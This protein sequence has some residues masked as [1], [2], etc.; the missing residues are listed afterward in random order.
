MNNNVEI[1]PFSEEYAEGV[2]N[3]AI[4]AWTPIRE[5]YR[6]LLGD[7]LYSMTFDN[8]QTSKA[9]GVLKAMRSGRG[10]L[11]VCDGELAGFVYYIFKEGNMS[12]EIG[13]NAVSFKYRGRG[14]AQLMYSHVIEKMKAE[15]ARFVTVVTGLDEG[16]A[17]ARR[18]Y[19]KAGFEKNLPSVCYY[20]RL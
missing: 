13:G 14:I 15:G 5:S 19:E 18:A 2:A 17:P 7:E 1:I 10:Y 6:N 20:K 8:W 16:H 11:A 12:G 3:L 9:N 4:E